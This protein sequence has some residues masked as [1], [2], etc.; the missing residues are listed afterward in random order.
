MT[1]PFSYDRFENSCDDRWPQSWTAHVNVKDSR[2]SI[3]PMGVPFCPED[4]ELCCCSFQRGTVVC[5]HLCVSAA[6]DEKA[7]TAEQ[8]AAANRGEAT[9]AAGAREHEPATAGARL[10]L[11]WKAVLIN[12][13]IAADTSTNVV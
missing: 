7:G 13:F 3:W 6:E 11:S 10:P 5:R 4:V 8:V 1:M 12:V 9:T 2:A